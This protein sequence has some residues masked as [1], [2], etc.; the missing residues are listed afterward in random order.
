MQSLTWSRGAHNLKGGVN[1]TRW[2]NDQN[3]SFTIGGNYRFNSIENFVRNITNTFEGQAPG[4]S[5]DREWRQN[6]IGL[7]V[8]D[9]WQMR[10]NLTLNAGLRYEFITVP[11]EN[12]G[13]VAT[14]ARPLRD[15]DIDGLAAVRQ[16]LAGER[17]TARRGSRGT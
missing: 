15:G 11:T 7:F 10:R 12:G 9:D 4:S 8:Q 5:T 13:R 2:F 16:P 3:S 1:L 6:L 17:R 14:H